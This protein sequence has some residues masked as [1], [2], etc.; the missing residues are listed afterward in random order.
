MVKT[1]SKWCGCLSLSDEEGF[2]TVNV[3]DMFTSFRVSTDNGVVTTKNLA[4][5]IQLF[6]LHENMTVDAGTVVVEMKHSCQDLTVWYTS[7]RGPNMY[8]FYIKDF[9]SFIDK[10]N[11]VCSN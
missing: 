11:V 9:D 10:V 5:A 1:V 2:I 8:N 6:R 3:D 4:T 7:R